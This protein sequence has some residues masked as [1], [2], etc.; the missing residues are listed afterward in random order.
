MQKR[1]L[2]VAPLPPPIG[3]DTVSSTRLLG[4]R[5]WRQADM[6]IDCINTSAGSGVKLVEVKRSWRDPLRA[7][8]ILCLLLLKLPRADIL[9]IWAN[10]SFI[11]S[12][13]IPVMAIA[14]F[15]RKPYIVKVFG[16]MLPERIEAYSPRRAGTI[17]DLL[18]K[19]DYILP[20]TGMLEDNLEK[21][22]GIDRDRLVRFPNFLPD[23]YFKIELRKEPFSG[24]CVFVG[25]IKDEK[26][27]FEILEAL[28]GRDDLSCEFY[29]PI[30]ERDRE[31]FLKE[32]SESGNCS[33]AGIIGPG[34]TINTI[35]RYNLLL[36]PTRHEG[37]GYPAVVLEAF[38]AGTPVIS[39]E[40]R[41]IP[42]LVE[43]GKRGIL[44][45]VSSPE[46]LLTA[47]DMLAR[48]RSMYDSIVWNA[49]EYAEKFSEKAVI[50]DLLLGLIKESTG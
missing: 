12:M 40:W 43:N 20:Q 32:I 29:G 22:T 48:D 44:I 28:K 27:V 18:R 46:R 16:A 25:Q 19:A 35:R 39:T 30:V 1:I 45:P 33:Y 4:S 23:S 7:L 37:E 9:L 10:S 49:A 21:I 5:Y 14:R 11:C 13:G 50:G 41:S 47:I 42:E 17:K 3:G 26:G 2:L 6:R 38:V 24:S 31:R 8:K 15:M 34:E 36:L